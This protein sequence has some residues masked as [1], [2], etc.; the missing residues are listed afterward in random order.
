MIQK[1][2]L[3]FVVQSLFH[4]RISDGNIFENVNLRM[5][6]EYKSHIIKCVFCNKYLILLLCKYLNSLS[7]ISNRGMIFSKY[8][9]KHTTRTHHRYNKNVLCIRTEHT[10]L[11]TKND[12]VIGFYAIRTLLSLCIHSGS[13]CIFNNF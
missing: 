10:A 11:A 7:C 9:K 3:E 1:R 8:K 5:E 2:V 12:I 4:S 6:N 13:Y